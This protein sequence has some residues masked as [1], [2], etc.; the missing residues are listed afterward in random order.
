MSDDEL[1]A[2][3]MRAICCPVGGCAAER[4]NNRCVVWHKDF[5]KDNKLQAAAVIKVIRES[6]CGTN[7]RESV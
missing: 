6:V 2:K 4:G 3:I 7:I 5:I 1:A